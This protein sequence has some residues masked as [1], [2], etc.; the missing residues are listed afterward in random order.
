MKSTTN[1]KWWLIQIYLNAWIHT[2]NWI[3]ITYFKFDQLFLSKFWDLN[4]VFHIG[5]SIYQLREW[6]AQTWE[7]AWWVHSKFGNWPGTLD[8]PDLRI[9]QIFSIICENTQIWIVGFSNFLFFLLF[10]TTSLNQTQPLRVGQ[11]MKLLT[12]PLWICLPP[13]ICLLVL[14]VASKNW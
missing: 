6:L 5:S 14:I 13:W 12:L 3:W 10:S 1:S 4:T 7:K 8:D 9:K 11:L 2:I